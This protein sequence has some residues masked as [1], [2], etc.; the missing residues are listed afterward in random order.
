MCRYFETFEEFITYR[1][2]D[3]SDCNLSSALKL[4]VDFS[5]YITNS[6]TV[7]PPS[8]AQNLTYSI[9]KEYRG[10]KFYD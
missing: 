2:G 5:K 10:D 8:N 7:L 4:N 6:G 3:L 1:N 9:K